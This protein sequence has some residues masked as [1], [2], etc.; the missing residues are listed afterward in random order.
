MAH[1][2]VLRERPETALCCNDQVHE[3][4]EVVDLSQLKSEDWWDKLGLQELLESPVS[5]LSL[6]S[7]LSD[8]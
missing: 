4:Q 6:C 7:S 1:S 8:C 5:L 2:C 3:E